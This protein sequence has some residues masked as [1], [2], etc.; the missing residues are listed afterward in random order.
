M[1][2]FEHTLILTDLDG[3]LLN[4]RGEIST[5]D[6]AAIRYYMENGGRFTVATGR[7]L[8]GMEHFFPALAV[9][10]PAIL[11]NGSV[12][13][14]FQTGQDLYEACVGQTG[15]ALARALMAALPAL[16]VEVYAGHRAY[17]AQESE[18]TH[19]PFEGVKLPWNPCPP[20]QIPQPWLYLVITGA[21]ETLARAEMLIRERFPGQF[22]AQYSS[23]TMLEI[24]RQ[25]ASKG[26]SAQFLIRK[27]GL[28]LE[29]VFPVGDGSN[30]VELLQCAPNSCAP[31]NACPQILA[32]AKHILPD[33]D[34]HTIAALIRRL[35]K[36]ALL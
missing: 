8:K 23:P 25:G 32:L 22:F 16:G 6:Q 9:N 2:Q 18:L 10:A 5:E 30:D 26:E 20:E 35:E 34:S 27:M 21:G 28:E 1:K 12:V 14:D 11:Y 29:R 19:R 15:Y 33:N 13:Y 24:L 31:E 36:G 3:T 7:S 17:V 4:G